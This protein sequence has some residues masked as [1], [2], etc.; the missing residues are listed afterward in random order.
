MSE[1]RPIE[2]A[3]KDGRRFIA[4]DGHE[5]W[6]AKWFEDE[7]MDYNDCSPLEDLEGW[8]P[9]PGDDPG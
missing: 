8:I 1:W 3:P 2:T 5:V 7:W 6:M 4:W 9:F